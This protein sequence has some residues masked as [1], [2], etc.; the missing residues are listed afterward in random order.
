MKMEDTSMTHNLIA[1]G[2]KIQGNITSEGDVRIDGTVEGTIES[3][4]KI[5]IGNNGK[6]I[7]TIIAKNIE[8]MGFIEGKILISSTLSLKST[9]KVKGD[10]TTATLVIEQ[11]AE[12][13]GTCK[14]GKEAAAASDTKIEV[15][16]KNKKSA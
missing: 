1:A 8:I 15:A 4:G 7:G 14:M 2:T 12:F 10:I 9:G 5:V 16:D 3:K 13:N 11:G 6:F